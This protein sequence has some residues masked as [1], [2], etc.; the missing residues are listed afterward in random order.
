MNS[1]T[2][3]VANA[4][5]C[6]RADRLLFENLG[7]HAAPGQLLEICGRNGSGKTTLL[8]LLCGL[9]QPDEGQITWQG[10]DIHAD[11]EVFRRALC[12]IGHLNGLK[13]DL[14][15]LE[16]LLADAR[17]FG[18]NPA[19]VEAALETLG[20]LREIDLP[21]QRLSAGQKQRTALARLL[22]RGTPLWILDEPCASLDRQAQQQVQRLLESH[23]NNGGT[24][25]FTT[26]QPL[27]FE[28]GNVTQLWLAEAGAD[29]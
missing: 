7:F 16:N 29:A 15:P 4:L 17:L 12:Y 24:V 9:R 23:A 5:A 28:Q 6:R 1:S 14:S 21:C 13:A 19:R 26:H 3:L 27:V 2:G 11:T 25:I 8:R 20:L 18:A 22:I 10:Q